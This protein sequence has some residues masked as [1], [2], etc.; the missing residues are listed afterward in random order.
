[1]RPLGI[2]WSTRG[3]ELSARERIFAAWLGP[4]G[5]VA[6]AIASVTATSLEAVGFEGG[7]EL[8]ALVFLTIA[9]TVVVL[10]GLAPVVAWGLDVRAP[11]RDSIVILGAEELALALGVAL[12]EGG[13]SV[14]F[15]DKNPACCRAAEEKGFPVV[16]G[17]AIS[18]T[19]LARLRLERA[20]IAIGL[21]TN[22]ELNHLFT[23]EAQEEYDVPEVY[24]AASRQASEESAR[25]AQ[26]HAAF[27]LFDRP[28]DVERWNVRLRH[29][30]AS[31]VRLEAHSRRRT[32]TEPSTLG[33]MPSSGSTDAFAILAVRRGEWRPMQADWTPRSGDEACALIHHDEAER[34]RTQLEDIGWKLVQSADADSRSRPRPRP[35]LDL[36]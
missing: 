22:I 18:A 21:T 2:L 29:R 11:G 5:V 36:N 25:L 16:F 7:A 30:A 9:L 31:I 13:L 20:R 27:V 26:R 12:R 14:V 8:R 3:S 32:E 15:T 35:R 1:V 4:R 28:K 23:L 33:G 6:A 19:T 10:G 24:V 17:D 34:A